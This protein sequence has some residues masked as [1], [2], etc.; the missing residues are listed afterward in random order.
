MDTAGTARVRWSLR[1][2]VVGLACWLSACGVRELPSDCA[3]LALLA[4]GQLAAGDWDDARR[5]ATKL[6]EVCASTCRDA[7]F[8]ARH[9][10]L[11]ALQLARCAISAA[12]DDERTLTEL[13]LLLL[14]ERED[15]TS[16]L[17]ALSRADLSVL[18]AAAR[19]RGLYRVEVWLLE[20]AVYASERERRDAAVTAELR[21]RLRAL[22][23][24]SPA[25]GAWLDGIGGCFESEACGPCD[26]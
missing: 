26:R 10:S 20:Q 6:R 1:A 7:Q 18:Q 15:G 11:A 14:A 5:T 2:G 4:E 12:P 8:E 23:P 3:A 17:S 16:E 9:T 25:A 22:S 24:W 13:R 21:G 19:Y